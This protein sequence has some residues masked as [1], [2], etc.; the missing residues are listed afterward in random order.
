MKIVLFPGQGSQRKGMG[1]ELFD[2]FPEYTRAADAVLGYSIRTLCLDD[3]DNQLGQTRY[4]QPAV[5]TVNCLSYLDHIRSEAKPDYVLGHSVGE[6]SALFVADIIDF[7]T[8]LRLVQ[9]RGALMAEARG[10]GMAAVIGLEEDGVAAVLQNPAL[11]NLSIANYNSPRQLVISG[12]KQDIVKAEPLFL[13]GGATHYRVLNVSGAFHTRYMAE[14]GKQFA[15]VVGEIRLNEPRLPLISNVTARPYRKARMLQHITDQ[16]TAPVKWTESIRYLMAQGATHKNLVEIGNGKSSVVKALAMRTMRAAE[17][18]DPALLAAEEAR[19]AAETPPPAP[20]EHP[21]Q[22]PTAPLAKDQAETP[23]PHAQREQKPAAPPAESPAAIPAPHERT[24]Q[25]QAEAPAATP[26]PET[27]TQKRRS[28][29][30]TE[31]PTPPIAPPIQPFFSA[32]AL[33]NPAFRAE[34][35]LRHAYLAGGM[36]RG[37]SSVEL[38]NRMTRAGYLAFYGTADLAPERVEQ[39]LRALKTT[40]AGRFYGANLVADIDQ[41]ERNETLVDLFLRWE[42]PV[43]EAAAFMQITP[44]LIRY[45]AAGLRRDEH[46]RIQSDRR[47]FA[48]VTRPETATAFLNP[49][50]ERVV[51]S[52]VAA[53]KLTEAQAALL[54]EVPMADA[55]IVAADSAWQTDEGMPYAVVPTL[56]RLRNEVVQHRGYHRNIYIGAAGGIG[57]AEAAAASFMLGCDFIL[58]GSVNQCTVEAATSDQAKDLLQNMNVQDTDYAPSGEAFELGTRVQVLKRGVF[59]PARARKLYDLYRHHHALEELDAKTVDQLQSR[60]F[61]RDFAAVFREVTEQLSPADRAK[62]DSDPKFKMS[63]VFRWYFSY[64][65]RLAQEGVSASKVDYQIHTGPAL[66]AFNQWVKGSPLEDWRNRHVDQIAEKIMTGA[67][68]ILNQRYNTMAHKN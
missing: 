7:E 43:V 57:T 31:A 6:Y 67:A 11:A 23:A 12:P 41:P 54:R 29:P 15:A 22:N 25:K 13:E 48:K 19:H 2:A 44:A 32:D 16:I 1:D 34:Y 17:P 26:A 30:Q 18:L 40:S 66:G 42:V 36:Y 65:S 38:V 45:R 55:L 33:G 3:P 50:P 14:A 39:D 10:G 59:F 58:T 35:Q 47:I 53:G 52:L 62:A 68:E 51:K 20:H 56:I 46:G 61:K 5:Y 9:K 60:Y 27:P 24:E 8:G 64:A 37:I 49:A 28:A 63:L 21:D 4:T